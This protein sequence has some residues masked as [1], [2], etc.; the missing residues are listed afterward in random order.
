MTQTQSVIAQTRRAPV[1]AP[2]TPAPNASPPPSR[3]YNSLPLTRRAAFSRPLPGTERRAASRS[4]CAAASAACSELK[5]PNTTR[6]IHSERR[7]ERRAESSSTV[8]G[9]P[10]PT[11]KQ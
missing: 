2:H 11:E 8:S 7:T 6:H 3:R 1:P 10:R 9:E 5:Q 4:A